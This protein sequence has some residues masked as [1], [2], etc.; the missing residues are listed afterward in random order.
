MQNEDDSKYLVIN[1]FSPADVVKLIR[2]RYKTIL[3][4]GLIGAIGGLLYVSSKSSYYRSSIAL[5]PVII[6][7]NETLIV[8][9]DL[10]NALNAES[11]ESLTVVI[12]GEGV[13]LKRDILKLSSMI[14]ENGLILITYETRNTESLNFIIDS[15]YAYLEGSRFVTSTSEIQARSLDST[16][17]IV[18]HEIEGLERLKDMIEKNPNNLGDYYDASSTF[19]Y[20]IPIQL[21]ELKKQKYS[22][23]EKLVLL[24]TPFIIVNNSPKLQYQLVKPDRIKFFLIALLGGLIA[25]IF[26]SIFTEKKVA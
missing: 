22:A 16:L 26:I 13:D 25:G 17:V 1:P 20:D 6:S 23:Q 21:V 19:H 15:T 5:K 2:S 10:E 12:G 18:N 7:P 11:E 4:F 9:K 8:L 14:G 3:L 24:E